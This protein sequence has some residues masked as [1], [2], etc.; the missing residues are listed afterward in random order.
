MPARRVVVPSIVLSE[1]DGVEIVWRA[2]GLHIS[3]EI[4]DG[5]E[6]HVEVRGLHPGYDRSLGGKP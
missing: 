5:V 6:P 3:I 4:D 1:E 2:N